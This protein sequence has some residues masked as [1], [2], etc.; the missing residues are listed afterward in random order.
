MMLAGLRSMESIRQ[1]VETIK[2]LTAERIARGEEVPRVLGR[3]RP[4]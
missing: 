2:R 4:I 1:E 3:D